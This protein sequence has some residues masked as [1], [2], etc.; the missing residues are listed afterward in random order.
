[1]ASYRSVVGEFAPF[2]EL[3]CLGWRRL[4]AG[5]A[6]QQGSVQSTLVALAY[7]GKGRRLGDR[8]RAAA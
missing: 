4:Q 7:R 8:K 1:M 2:L 5:W 6:A 3:F